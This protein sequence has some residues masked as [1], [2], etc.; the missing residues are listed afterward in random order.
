MHRKMK[1]RPLNAAEIAEIQRDLQKC[2]AA[3]DAHINANT[4]TS[5]Y[6]Y[7][8]RLI[9]TLTKWNRARRIRRAT[10]FVATSSGVASNQ[11]RLNLLIECTAGSLGKMGPARK[12]TEQKRRSKWAR[13]VYRV[14]AQGV[15]P[16]KIVATILK[17][18][19][20][21]AVLA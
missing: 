15:T 20:F 14:K 11:K 16:K 12:L 6:P 1:S 3:W 18:G 2:R 10:H 13:A 8:D 4:R 9:E 5:I 19:G 7:L 17:R 21:N